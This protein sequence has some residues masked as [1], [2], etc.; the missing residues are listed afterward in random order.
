MCRELASHG[1]FVVC[2][3]HNDR[4]ADYTPQ[5]AYFD[6][7]IPKYTLEVKKMQLQ[8]RS[9]EITALVDEVLQKKFL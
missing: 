2:L 9:N 1:F 7:S 4:T 3:S 5:V 6:G 8:I